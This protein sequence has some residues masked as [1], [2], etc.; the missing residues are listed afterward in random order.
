M[1]YK[2]NI[3]KKLKNF[4]L[5]NFLSKLDKKLSSQKIQIIIYILLIGG[6][7]PPHPPFIIFFLLE[8]I[9]GSPHP[10]FIIRRL[11]RVLCLFCL[12][13]LGLFLR[14]VEK[15]FKEEKNLVN[16]IIIYS[17][18]FIIIQRQYYYQMI[19]VEV[20]HQY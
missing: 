11:V 1:K 14:V 20:S 19:L 9:I 13:V 17:N 12:L 3:Q 15:G 18:I 7:A 16:P 6:K 5:S 4:Q 2:F 10:P 8:R